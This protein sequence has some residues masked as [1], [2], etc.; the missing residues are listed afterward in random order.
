MHTDRLYSAYHHRCGGWWRF[1]SAGVGWGGVTS[2]SQGERSMAPPA[3]MLL[4][5]RALARPA[6]LLISACP[7]TTHLHS[8]RSHPPLV[9]RLRAI[10]A[11]IAAASKKSR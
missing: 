3:F 5:T 1:H 4:Y 2:C 9:Q 7:P 6:A 10:N 11:G 8:P